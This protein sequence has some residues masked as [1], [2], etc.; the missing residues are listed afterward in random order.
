MKIRNILA[1]ALA[2]AAVTLSVFLV[3]CGN[4]R[5]LFP[6]GGGGVVPK[7][8]YTI[9]DFDISGY[10]V[11]SSTGAVTP[12]PGSPFV[13]G[14]VDSTCP[15]LAA[16][17]PSGK[18]L[19]VPDACNDTV[20][21]YGIDQTTG[22]LT[23]VAGS[24]FA[25]GATGHLIEQPVVDSTGKF[26]YVPTTQSDQIFG[27]TIAA[28]G[29][30]A[31]ITGSPFA[32]GGGES[33][34]IVPSGKFLYEADSGGSNGTILGFSIN[35]TSGALTPI[36]GPP[37]NLS[38]QPKFIVASPTGNFLYLTAPDT[39]NLLILTYDPSTGA[40][41]ETTG[42]PFASGS[43]NP[44]ALDISP[45]GKFLYVT[46]L[47][48]PES[49]PAVAGSVLAFS[50]NASTGALTAVPGSPYTAGANPKRIA[51][52]PSGKFV[53]VTNEDAPAASGNLGLS[54]FR[55]DSTTGTLSEIAGSPFK[56]G[57]GA[58]GV[59]IIHQ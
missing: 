57:A 6:V 56:T 40:V 36:S 10:T 26:L 25:T 33:L 8:L 19:F 1:T 44:E 49:T 51:A 30:L 5:S 11:N 43:L 16:A 29:S 24:P 53:Y 46:N 55:I 32:A 7:F 13:L 27:F 41:T 21:V 39:A 12:S 22:A 38:S 4:D 47:G 14:N 18:F 2:L 48:D 45:T 35:A 42:S 17:S 28:N 59:T 31:A 15:D 52:D 9:N 50:I 20:L 54:V 37:F 23:A 34:T 58:E 3:S